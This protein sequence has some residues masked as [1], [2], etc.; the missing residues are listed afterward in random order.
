MIDE[1]DYVLTECV[2]PERKRVYMSAVDI[3]HDY[4]FH[5]FDF[6]IQNIIPVQNIIGTEQMITDI[7]NVI[8]TAC[9]T[10]FREHGLSVSTDALPIKVAILRGLKDIQSFEDHD[11]VVALCMDGGEA[12]E[13]FADLM[14]LVVDRP[15]GEVMNAI[16][17][18]P[19]N[20]IE[21]LK[22]LHAQNSRD[23]ET[24]IDDIQDDM[25]HARTTE[26]LRQ[27]V[28]GYMKRTQ[29]TLVID[30]LVQEGYRVG[31]SMKHYLGGAADKLAS[32]E[33]KQPTQAAR[34]LL[35]L[36]LATHTEEKDLKKLIGETIEE[37]YADMS[38]ITDVDIAL[39]DE[40]RKVVVHNGQT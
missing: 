1:L 36:A 26:V 24:E 32:Y 4:D 25:L 2:S 3:L 15:W 35:S 40:M 27:R 30:T 12:S 31:A 29:E 22:E 19:Q 9:D 8:N 14:E 13:I 20:L 6:E 38:F 18:V 11:T 33:P 21:R 7:H 28:K 16:S 23:E 34:D 37:I 10:V 17:A 39:T 5:S